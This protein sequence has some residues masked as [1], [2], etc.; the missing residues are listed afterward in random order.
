MDFEE[1]HYLCVLPNIVRVMKSHGIEWDGYGAHTGEK[2]YVYRILVG[3]REG[4][5]PL[6][7]LELRWEDNIRKELRG[8]KMRCALDWNHMA[9]DGDKLRALVSTIT[10]LRGDKLQGICKL[11]EELLLT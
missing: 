7:R 9:Q 10:K 2:V 1:L 6:G 8:N 11:S 3:K 4:K 5:R